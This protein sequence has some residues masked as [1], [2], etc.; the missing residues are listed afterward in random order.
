MKK[1]KLIKVYFLVLVVLLVV[2]FFFVVFL[3]ELLFCFLVLLFVLVLVDVVLFFGAC[4]TVPFDDF[5]TLVLL[6][7]ACCLLFLVYCLF[8]INRI[9][10]ATKARP[11]NPRTIH[12]IINNTL[13]LFLSFLSVLVVLSLLSFWLSL[14]Y[15]SSFLV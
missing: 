13:L 6:F 11:I 7:K 10:N 14:F 9:M 3:F 2:V 1:S 4:L 15:I 8:I 12:K 5:N